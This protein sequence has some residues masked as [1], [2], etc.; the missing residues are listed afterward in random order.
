MCSGYICLFF[1]SFIP[2][3]NK[4]KNHNQNN[5]SVEFVTRKVTC[6]VP[7]FLFLLPIRPFSPS[8]FYFPFL[9]FLFIL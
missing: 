7:F 1:K 9:F 5:S 2:K 4:V 8:P 3:K 6:L